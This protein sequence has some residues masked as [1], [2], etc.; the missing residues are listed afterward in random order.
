[1]MKVLS[2]LTWYRSHFAGLTPKQ[3]VFILT[4]NPQ[5][6]KLYQEISQA[7]NVDMS[8][9]IDVNDFVVQNLNKF[10]ELENFLGFIDE[11]SG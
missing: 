5:T 10:P 7:A 1:M 6:K 2:V 9:I 3:K 11:E 4:S 8:A